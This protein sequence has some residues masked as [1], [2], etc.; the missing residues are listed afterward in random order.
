VFVVSLTHG[1]VFEI[2]RTTGGDDDDDGEDLEF[3]TETDLTGSQEVPPVMTDMTGNAELV[4]E[5]GQLRVRLMVRNNTNEIFAAHIHCAPP[6]ENGAIGLTLFMGSFTARRGVLVRDFFT[7]P[8]P[9]NNCGWESID[10][11]ARAIL[12]GNAYVNVHT[13]EESGGVPSGEIRGDIPLP[14]H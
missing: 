8:D 4:F 2:F 13:T 12:D 7:E 10:D 11:I 14:R 1:A 9:E 5:G 3:E 6:G